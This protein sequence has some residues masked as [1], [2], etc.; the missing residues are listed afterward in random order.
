MVVMAHRYGHVDALT[1]REAM[2]RLDR[3]PTEISTTRTTSESHELTISF[4][5]SPPADDVPVRHS[6]EGPHKS[7]HNL[8]KPGPL[9]FVSY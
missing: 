3:H 9:I 2:A 8:T 7:P 1:Q 4:G 5:H 6:E